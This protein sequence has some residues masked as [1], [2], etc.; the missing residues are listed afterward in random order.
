MRIVNID[1]R[2]AIYSGF[3]GAAVEKQQAFFAAAAAIRVAAGVRVCL[4]STLKEFQMSTFISAVRTFIADEEG[5]TALEYGMIAALIAGV[6]VTAV[7]LLGTSVS[8]TFTDIT[9]A[10]S[11]K[12]T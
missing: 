10:M 11:G 5:V 7:G 12:T 4:L 2:A 6:I 8:Q 1:C 3:N 9:K